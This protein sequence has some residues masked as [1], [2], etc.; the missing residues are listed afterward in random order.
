MRRRRPIM[1]NGPRLLKATLLSRLTVRGRGGRERRCRFVPFMLLI[2]PSNKLGLGSDTANGI[3]SSA[4]YLVL[5]ILH[6]VW[7]ILSVYLR[8][9]IRQISPFPTF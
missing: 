8:T 1:Q 7:L 2:P 5:E 6:S 4:F 3:Y 9:Y